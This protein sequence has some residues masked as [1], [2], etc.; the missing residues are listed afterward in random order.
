MLQPVKNREEVEMNK[1]AKTM[2]NSV[3]LFAK[4]YFA[5]AGAD[6]SSF[7]EKNAVFSE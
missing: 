3:R 7:N 1:I 2:R 5:F 6:F 4:I